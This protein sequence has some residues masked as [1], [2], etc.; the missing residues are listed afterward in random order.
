M[1]S[2]IRLERWLM[3]EYVPCEVQTTLGGNGC[4]DMCMCVCVGRCVWVCVWG[5]HMYNV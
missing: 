3:S 2:H 1:L 4:V 5:N